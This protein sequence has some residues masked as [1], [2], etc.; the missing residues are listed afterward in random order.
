MALFLAAFGHVD[1]PEPDADLRRPR[2]RRGD[3]AAV[4]RPE[5]RLTAGERRV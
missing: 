4:R 3:T 1:L 5:P 2:G